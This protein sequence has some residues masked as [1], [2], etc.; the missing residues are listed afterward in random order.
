MNKQTLRQIFLEKRQVLSQK[1]RANRST[2]VCQQAIQ[3]IKDSP[4]KICH[5]FMY[6]DS[7][8]E[9]NTDPIFNFLVSSKEHTAVTSKCDF[10][11][12]ILTHFVCESTTTFDINKYGIKEPVNGLSIE[13]KE[14]DLVFVPLISFDRQGNRIGYGGGFYDKFL[15]QCSEDCLKIGLATSPPLDLIPYTESHDIK[16]DYCLT[17]YGRY[18]FRN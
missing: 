18:N 11:K 3:I 9:V 12:K 1:E 4:I 17:H 16:L 14:I 15:S 10:S 13:E 7:F 6:M 8:A 5:I 2:Q